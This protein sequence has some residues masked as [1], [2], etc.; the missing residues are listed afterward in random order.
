[1]TA[2]WIKIPKTKTKMDYETAMAVVRRINFFVE[3]EEIHA[4][5]PLEINFNHRIRSTSLNSIPCLLNTSETLYNK[6][7][8][9]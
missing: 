3:A 9:S 7:I 2:Q 1:M 6:W 5:S 8:A 4:T